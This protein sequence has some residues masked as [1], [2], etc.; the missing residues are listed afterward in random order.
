VGTYFIFNK[1]GTLV[2]HTYQTSVF[3]ALAYLNN[4]CVDGE[5]QITTQILSAAKQPGLCTAKSS[6]VFSYY[7]SDIHPCSYRRLSPY[8]ELC[9]RDKPSAVLS[10]ALLTLVRTFVDAFS[11]TS[12][13]KTPSRKSL[14]MTIGDGIYT[15]GSAI[16]TETVFA[17]HC[18]LMSFNLLLL[19]HSYLKSVRADQTGKPAPLILI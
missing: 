8:Y 1:G 17:Q 7:F 6:W 19:P 2:S 13:H 14:I 5:D 10:S 15:G 9:A 12:T 16:L 18:M 4:T 11:H 3:R